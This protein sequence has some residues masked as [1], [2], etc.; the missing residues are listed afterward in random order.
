VPS[1]PPTS[2]A[3]PAAFVALRAKANDLFV[4]PATL[5]ATL[6]QPTEGFVI[7]DAGAGTVSLKSSTTGKYVCAEKAG[8]A[9]LALDRTAVGP[10][11]KFT[12][13]SNTD[14]TVSLRAVNG[15]YVCADLNATA[16]LVANRTAI[17]PWEKFERVTA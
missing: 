16:G 1:V 10:W 7:E 2:S 9:P 17:G 6:A 14:G 5:R 8:A 12:L 3:P 15:M 4:S 11:E 13:V